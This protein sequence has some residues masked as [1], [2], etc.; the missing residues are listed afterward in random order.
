MV[1]VIAM[2][3][4]GMTSCQDQA[5]LP[6]RGE[7][8]DAPLRP[9]PPKVMTV[10]EKVA[11]TVSLPC[12]TTLPRAIQACTPGTPVGELQAEAVKDAGRLHGVDFGYCVPSERRLEMNHPNRFLHFVMLDGSS[13]YAKASDTWERLG[14]RRYAD[15]RGTLFFVGHPSYH[16]DHIAFRWKE[17]GSTYLASLHSWDDREEAEGLLAAIVETS[18]FIR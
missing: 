18:S 9:V 6:S 13:P 3:L 11:R 1:L 12:P 17:R 8:A 14:G 4:G 10:C 16:G 5:A 15:R 2:L 7:V